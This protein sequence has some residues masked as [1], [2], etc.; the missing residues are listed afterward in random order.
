MV[1]ATRSAIVTAVHVPFVPVPRGSRTN[2]QQVV[3]MGPTQCLPHVMEVVAR[4][5]LL[6]SRRGGV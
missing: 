2:V 4:A 6:A 3:L 1:R 5:K